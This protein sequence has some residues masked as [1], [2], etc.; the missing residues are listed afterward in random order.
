MTLVEL[1]HAL[2]RGGADGKMKEL[3]QKI[4]NYILL[5]LHH[6]LRTE[7]FTVVRF[8]PSYRFPYLTKVLGPTVLMTLQ[9]VR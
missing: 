8:I 1:V 5:D 2:S 9:V 4:G 6:R 7:F 3:C